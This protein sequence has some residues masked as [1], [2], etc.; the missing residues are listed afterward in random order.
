MVLPFVSIA[1]GTSVLGIWWV[2]QG[3]HLDSLL[4]FDINFSAATLDSVRQTSAEG[5]CVGQGGPIA[6]HFENV[7]RLQDSPADSNTFVIVEKPRLR[8]HP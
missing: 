5:D 1:S 8:N 7:W 6:N 3:G 2:S 4:L